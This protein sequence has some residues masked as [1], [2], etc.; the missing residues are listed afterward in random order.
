MFGENRCEQCNQS[1]NG[2]TLIE[3]LVVTSVIAT[4]A[5]FVY[6]KYLEFVRQ[7]HRATAIADLARIQ[8]ELESNFNGRYQ[9]E[10]ILSGGRCT[11]CQTDQRRFIFSITSGANTA[12]IIKA[13]AQAD[14]QQNLDV[15]LVENKT[16]ELSLDAS[17]NQRPTTCWP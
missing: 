3:L 11:L 4:L 8:L 2:M 1:L 15:C 5:I 13:T 12:Y 14:T 16:N 9:W 6:P 10:H 7:S 17:N